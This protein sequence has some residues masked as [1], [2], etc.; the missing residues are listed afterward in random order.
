MQEDPPGAAP[1]QAYT[2]SDLELASRLSFFLWS[3]IPDAEL[4]DVAERGQLTDPAI[5][6][7]HVQRMLAD[8]RSEALVSN[9]PRSGC[10]CGTSTR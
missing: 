3:S 4:L 8:P 10:T 6:R 1:G 5:K 7:R 9:S 2:L